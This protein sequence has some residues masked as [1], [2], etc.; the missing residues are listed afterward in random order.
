MPNLGEKSPIFPELSVEVNKKF[1][2][3]FLFF[4]SEDD[5]KYQNGVFRASQMKVD[6]K[7]YSFVFSFQKM[8]KNN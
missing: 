7:F 6:S 3:L 5:E 4:S 2:L 8:I 1:Q